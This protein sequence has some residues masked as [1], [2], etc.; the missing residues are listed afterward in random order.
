MFGQKNW[1]S[2][3][4]PA[5]AGANF[6]HLTESVEDE[7]FHKD[8]DI[9][10]WKQKFIKYTPHHAAVIVQG[11]SNAGA[12]KTMMG[13]LTK[14]PDVLYDSYTVSGWAG[15]KPNVEAGVTKTSYVN[16]KALYINKA[17]KLKI[18]TQTLFEVDG[19]VQLILM[20]LMGVLED[21][22]SMI[23]W[24]N[25][26]EQL[27]E[28]S[29]FDVVHMAPWIGFPMQG[30]PDL[31]YAIGTVAFHPISFEQLNR[32]IA[33]C[34]INYDGAALKGKGVQALPL[35]IAS[36]A[37]VSAS[38]VDFALANT[39]V[40]VSPEERLSLLN[41]YNE[42]IYK[43]HVKAGEHT[44]QPAATEKKVIFDLNIK[45]PCTYI[46]LTIQSR[47]DVEAG[48]WT[49]LCDDYGLDYIRECMLITGTTPREDSVTAA[50][51]RT[52]KIIE[53]FKRSIRRH[54]YLIAFETNANSKVFTGHQTMTNVEK[55]QF[56]CIV[57]P[58]KSALDF[59]ADAAVY[60]GAYT[61]RGG[62]GKIW[63]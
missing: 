35:E 52:G 5:G 30:R 38:T 37:V 7:V 45:G 3:W 61:E 62:G 16:G 46:W 28:E 58:H 48:N 20:E 33:E 1:D 41:G 43:E 22:A 13:N 55:L 50:Y 57:K 42:I 29:R 21:Y 18:A 25:T 6:A 26:R 63:G 56:S 27:I 2:Q 14:T 31:T 17:M 60:N 8:A 40:W 49:K 10:Q 39:C 4:R 47:D 23:G 36:N 24:C 54:V 15:I 59:R 11:L 9:T 53:C 44:E 34:V 19:H 32:S 12:G 51:L